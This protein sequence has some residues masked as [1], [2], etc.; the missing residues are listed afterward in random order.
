MALSSFFVCTISPLLNRSLGLLLTPHIHLPVH[1]QAMTAV[2]K[3][4]R[5]RS[6]VLFSVKVALIAMILASVLIVAAP[7]TFPPSAH[8]LLV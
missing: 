8:I 6:T 4:V 5:R 3:D 7:V 1:H 2:M